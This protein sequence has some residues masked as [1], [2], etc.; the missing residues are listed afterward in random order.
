MGE[1]YILRACLIEVLLEQRDHAFREQRLGAPRS[2]M[3]ELDRIDEIEDLRRERLGVFWRTDDALDGRAEV[4]A[5]S[6]KV[7][8]DVSGVSVVHGS[9]RFRFRC[10]FCGLCRFCGLRGCRW[11]W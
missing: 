2:R 4:R 10:G 8:E 9:D 11:W 6:Q 5:T 7:E 1:A 3:T